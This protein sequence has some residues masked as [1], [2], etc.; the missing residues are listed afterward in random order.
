MLN[1]DRKTISIL[2]S[3]SP[4]LFYYRNTFSLNSLTFYQNVCILI[5]IKQSIPRSLTI[6]LNEIVTKQKNFSYL[7]YQL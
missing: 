3:Y 6:F 1:F 2:Y 5:F 7:D 4:Y